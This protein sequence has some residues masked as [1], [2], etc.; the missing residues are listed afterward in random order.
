MQKTFLL[1]APTYATLTPPDRFRWLQ[2]L[3]IERRKSPA[4]VAGLVGHAERG[5]DQ[6]GGPGITSG[7]TSPALFR[8]S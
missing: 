6:L 8:R 5:R 1:H 4:G 7:S 2:L 3:D